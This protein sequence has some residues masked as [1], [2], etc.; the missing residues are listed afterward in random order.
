MITDRWLTPPGPRLTLNRGQQLV[1]AVLVMLL[2]ALVA[3]GFQSSA[4]QNAYSQHSARSE[5]AT[6]NTLFTVRDSLTYIDRAQ[7]YLLG[8]VPRRDVQLARAMLAQRLRVIATNGLT[9]ADSTGPDYRAALAALDAVVAKA[10]PGLL[11]VGQRDQ[12]AGTILPRSE[13]LSERAHE[14]ATDNQVEQHRMD[15]LAERNLLR[16]RVVQLAMLI[17]ALILAAILLWWVSANV[18]RQYR[19]ARKAFDDER[20]VLRQ[21]EFRLDRVS[22]LERGQAQILER[23][24]TAGP[25]SSVLRQIVQLAADV[26]GAPAVRMSIGR[27]TV[28]YPPGADVSGTPAWT[29]VVTDNVD[30]SGTLQVF[31]DAEALD[32]LAHTAL[33]RCR[34]LA[35]LSLERDASARRL[36]YQASHDALTGLANRS[37]LLTRLSKSLLLSRRRGT[38]LAL[39]FC[40]LD[41]FKM[42]NDSIG[43]AGG[44][45]LLIEAARRLSGT[46]RESDTV[47]RLGGDEFVVLCPEL[48]DRTQ[49]LALANRIRT[50]L[51]VPYTIDG[52]EA[53]V[54]VSIGITFAD[55]STVSGHELMREADVAM[56]RAKLTDGHHINV[57]DS[58][59]EA[60]VAQRLD[61]DAALRHAVE[62]G[63]LRCSAQP[64]V[65]LDTGV[66]TGFEMLLQWHRPGLPVL[67]PGAFIPLAEDNGMIVEIGR[68][69]LHETIQTLAQWRADG[70]AL[71]LTMSVN[72][73]PR[74]VR[75][76]GFAE[77]VLQMLAAAGLPPEA[78]MIEL[79]EHA[80]V[81]LRVAHPTLARLREAGVSV[82]LD[83]FGTGYSSLTQ[84]RT[85]PVDQ[86]KLDRSFA[87][88]LD[89]GDDKQRAV[90]QSVVALARALSLDLVVEGIETI[91][92]R[93]TLLD[94]GADKGQGFLYHHPVLWDAARALLESGGVCPVPSDGGYTGLASSENPSPSESTTVTSQLP[95][96]S[97]ST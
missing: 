49:A 62:R 31:G 88:A 96:P 38:P 16:G 14:L 2:I 89:E 33:V 50:A 43:H 37:L 72:V 45:Q 48:P 77:E 1:A 68:W 53:F 12:W 13:A 85:L 79:T 15:R 6:T 51:S 94:L 36:S 63:E 10:P 78:L 18:V 69:V 52:K 22:A 47:A 21:T 44:D 3:I 40:D 9:A 90:V 97:V 55:E 84:L 8:V 29:G 35:V 30:G 19:S 24:A 25:V 71:D 91:A 41:R 56:Y 80:L 17:S 76:T 92:E 83:D 67:Y 87:A 58:T 81:D 11:P 27:R 54:D 75:E 20:E 82:S 65:V 73:S 93:D 95:S 74:Q 59:L 66:I 4:D 64:I 86:I 7:Q 5:A 60:E 70:L 42:V 46:V 57:F 34:D 23:I 32:E 39:L 61:L 28:I 26:S